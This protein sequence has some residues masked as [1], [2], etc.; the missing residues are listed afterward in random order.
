MKNI[1]LDIAY[2]GSNFFGS[3]RQSNLR[4]IQGEIEL[5]LF[6]LLN[7][8]IDLVFAGRTDR[9][10]HANHQVVNFTT[11]SDFPGI[12]YKFKLRKYLPD[13]ILII[14]SREV[15][16][17]FHARFDAK[18]KRYRYIIDNG[19]IFYPYKKNYSLHIKHDLDIKKMIEASKLLLGRHDFSAFMK[20]DH[21]YKNPI[22]RLNDISIIKTDN[23][24]IHIEFEAESFLYNQ[25]R[26]MVGLLID[27]GRGFRDLNYIKEIF[28]GKIK[29][30]AKTYGPEGLYLLKIKY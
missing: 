13:D 24:E 28:D 17:E 19:K 18:I 6:K 4:T 10:V 8:K 15:S 16:K 12:S 27:I 11:K 29:R 9:G 21:E 23:D 22:R 26:I 2:D 3:Q 1:R 30:A 20:L 14:N 5:A 7:E 25:I